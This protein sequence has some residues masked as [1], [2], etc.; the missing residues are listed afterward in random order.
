MEIYMLVR[1]LPLKNIKKLTSSIRFDLGLRLKTLRIDLDLQKVNC[2]QIP[3]FHLFLTVVKSND[4]TFLLKIKQLFCLIIFQIFYTQQTF[5]ILTIYSLKPVQLT[6]L[7]TPIQNW[8]H[9]ME[10]FQKDSII[11]YKK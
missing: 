6:Y 9:F 3:D 2:K 8:S 7:K 10:P 5:A 1:F 11:G 4:E